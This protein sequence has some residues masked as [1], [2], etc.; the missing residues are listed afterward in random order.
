M[1]A[2]AQRTHRTVTQSLDQRLGTV[3]TLVEQLI[4]QDEGLRAA[5]RELSGRTDERLHELQAIA[6]IDG[7]RLNRLVEA[8]ETLRSD[9]L[10]THDNLWLDHVALSQRLKVVEAHDVQ[11]L[12]FWSRLR[13][14]VTGC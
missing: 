8:V 10:K 1:N 2:E 5:G 4:A 3:E 6:R 12:T 14:L 13:W 11:H 9:D 7:G